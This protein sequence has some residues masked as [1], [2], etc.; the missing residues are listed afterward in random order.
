MTEKLLTGT[1]S[2]NTNKLLCFEDE[3]T[4]SSFEGLY[5]HFSILFTGGA[6]SHGLEAEPIPPELDSAYGK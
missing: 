2:L 6:A 3:Q 1:L 4:N 5:I